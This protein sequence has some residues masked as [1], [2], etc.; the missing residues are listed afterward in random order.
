[1]SGMMWLIDAV[2]MLLVLIAL[3]SRLQSGRR[4]PSAQ[5]ES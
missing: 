3:P 2:L 5:R 1:M 4:E